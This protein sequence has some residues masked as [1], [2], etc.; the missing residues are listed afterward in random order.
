M[1]SE[2]RFCVM[3]SSPQ[4]ADRAAAD[5]WLASAALEIRALL[6]DMRRIGR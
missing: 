4:T 6:S 2:I 3:T 1:A 5:Q